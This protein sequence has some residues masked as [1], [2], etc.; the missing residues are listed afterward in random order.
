MTSH[1]YYRHQ[2]QLRS[3]RSICGQTT[4]TNDS[5]YHDTVDRFNTITAAMGNTVRRQSKNRARNGEQLDRRTRTRSRG[6]RSFQDH[7]SSRTPYSS[8]RVSII[9]SILL[10]QDAPCSSVKDIA[11]LELTPP[12]SPI[13]F[14]VLDHFWRPDETAMVVVEG[15]SHVDENIENIPRRNHTG[16]RKCSMAGR[17]RMLTVVQ[18]V[19]AGHS[20]MVC[21]ESMLGLQCALLLEYH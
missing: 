8:A 5:L 17:R 15:F 9:W 2:P 20:V 7:M 11:W 13:S 3:S 14:P 12:P 10:H 16:K 18:Q 21:N 4:T 6:R 1:S 19:P